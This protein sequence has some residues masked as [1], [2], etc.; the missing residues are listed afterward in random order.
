MNPDR[1]EQPGLG[2][3]R[4]TE[5][6]ER[7]AP[8]GCAEVLRPGA[9]PGIARGA[10]LALLPVALWCLTH[11][12]RGLVGDAEL[13]AVQALSRTETGL[14]RDVFLGNAS[15]D[16]FTIFSPLYSFFIGMV[17]LRTAAISLLLLFKTCFYAAAWGFSRKLSDSRMASL[18]T[19]LLIL[20]PGEYGAYHVFH[21]AEDMLTARSLAEA[22]AMTGLCLQV[23]GHKTAALGLAACAMFAHPLIALPVVLLLLSLRLGVRARILWAIVAVAGALVGA[24]AA[25]AA[26]RL[27]RGVLTVMDPAWLEV[28]RERSQFVFLQLWRVEDWELNARPFISLA[29]SALVLREPRIRS[30][31][32]CALIVGTAGLATA[33]VAGVVGP[34]AVLLQG[35]AWRWTWV[36]ELLSVLFLVPSVREMWRSDRC[37]SACA[38]LLI[39]G[40]LF[41]VID[42]VYCIAAALC[43]WAGRRHVPATAA[44]Y[45]RFAAAAAATLAVGW[46][47]TQGWSALTPL[48]SGSAAESKALR[49]AHGVLGLDLLPAIVAFLVWLAIIAG[50]SVGVPAMIALA[51]GTVTS[52]AAP[53]ALHDP[54]I[55]GS[56]AQVDEFSDWRGAVPTGANVFV[57]S[58]YYSAGFAWFTLERPSYLTVDQSSGVIFSRATAIE[59]RR[60]SEV[61]RPIEDPDWR[62]LSRRS[63]HGGRYDAQALPLTAER[64]LLVCAD[65]E[66]GFVVAKEDVGFGPLRHDHPGPWNGWNLYDCGRVRSA[67]KLR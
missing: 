13:Y 8:D 35:Q 38:V 30:L 3:H 40:S 14:A 26:P 9:A 31:C 44:P 4:M 33:F 1:F 17:G 10:A 34:L 29:L 37:G 41:S 43:L 55:D 42:G 47:I 63:T 50:R 61:L 56:E 48:L 20:M 36:P 24:E 64:L 5:T 66:L 59:I 46:I 27:A 21:I 65:P 62:L 12:Y 60:R 23:H 45:L 53:D 39:L 25:T 57:A 67:G 54:R 58:R 15:Q 7:R 2:G 22:L 19:I 16:R 18:T 49:V 52:F 6:F 32:I 11:R 28:V 51:L